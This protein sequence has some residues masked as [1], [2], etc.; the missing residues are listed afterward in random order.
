MVKFAWSQLALAQVE[1]SLY[2]AQLKV[3]QNNLDSAKKR[4]QAGSIALVDYERAQ[5]ESLDMQ[6]LYQQA[7]LS[8]Q[9]A[10]RQLSN[11]WGETK[12]DIQLN[13]TSMPWPDQS[14]AT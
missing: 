3:S 13:A 5:I 6:R 4:Y 9:V 11:L 2:A 8:E 10:Q 7:V 14:D 1:K 12:A